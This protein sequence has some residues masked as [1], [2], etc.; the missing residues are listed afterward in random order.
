[1]SK[2]IVTLGSGPHEALLDLALR[3]FA[4]YAQRHGYAL[5]V[6]REAPSGLGRPAPWGK[7]PILRELASSNDVVV[8]LDSDLMILDG[9]VD[10]ATQLGDGA[11]MALAEHTTA[12]S[13]MPNTGVWVL[14]GGD[15]AVRMLDDVWAQEDLTE[16]QWW[17]NAAVCRLLGYEL[18]P[19]R[20]GE[21]TQLRARTTFLDGRWNSIPDAPAAQPY[22]RHYPGYKVRTRRAF[23]TRDLALVAARRATRRW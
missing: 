7:I 1:M 21:P 4:P 5:H 3:S 20:P 22:I 13:Q 18:D 17:E 15:D 8:W 11:V 2:A 12:G 10:I 9:R 19:V 6:H 16:H 23:M 14:R